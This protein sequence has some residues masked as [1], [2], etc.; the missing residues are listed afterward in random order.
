MTGPM[1][2]PMIDVVDVHKSFAGGKVQALAGVDLQVAPGEFLAITG[3]SGSGKSTLLHLIAALDAPDRGRIA[4]DGMDV[5]RLHDANRYRRETIGLVFQLHDLLPHLDAQ[6]NVEIP[7]FS[8]KRSLRERRAAA[9]ELLGAVGLG[10]KE[11]RRPPELSGG[12]RQRV[13]VARSLANDPRVL[14]A[15][16]P[17]GSLD[18]EAVG[19]L[20]GLFERLRAERGLTIVLVTH[21]DA[22]ASVADRKA[23]MVDGVVV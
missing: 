22:V 13:A 19:Q 4:V 17:T 21:D 12:E 14:L 15:D 9:V 16:E 11:H 2:G 3:S 1:S 23:R 10:G 18:T 7:M 6:Q 8:T 20:L 5:T